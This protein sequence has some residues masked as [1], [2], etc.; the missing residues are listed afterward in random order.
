MMYFNL[1]TVF[2]FWWNRQH[3]YGII[4][5]FKIQR[6]FWKIFVK[7]C[8]SGRGIVKRTF[9]T[10]CWLHQGYQGN[11]NPQGITPKYFLFLHL[12]IS[13]AFQEHKATDHGKEWGIKHSHPQC[14][15]KEEEIYQGIYPKKIFQTNFKLFSQNN[16]HSIYFQG[17]VHNDGGHE[18]AIHVALLHS[19]VPS[20]KVKVKLCWIKSESKKNVD[21]CWLLPFQLLCLMDSLRRCLVCFILAKCVMFLFRYLISYV[22]GDFEYYQTDEDKRVRFQILDKDTA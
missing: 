17:H 16:F 18:V 1:S 14:Q 13:L 7:Y 22:H 9:S 19:Q 8:F 3:E 11:Q 15:Q 21:L 20:E 4:W 10:K 12:T 5:Q 6:K 2:I